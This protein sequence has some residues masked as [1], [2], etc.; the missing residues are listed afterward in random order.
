MQ[1]I[2]Q[3]RGIGKPMMKILAEIAQER[4]VSIFEADVFGGNHH[5]I[6]FLEHCGY[7][8]E[9][10]FDSNTIHVSFPIV[11]TRILHEERTA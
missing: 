9:H 10:T 3:H 5:F 1:A 2:Y 7:Q 8:L 11:S 6:Q 4:G